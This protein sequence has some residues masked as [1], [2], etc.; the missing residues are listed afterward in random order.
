M[1]DFFN[2][3]WATRNIYD[4]TSDSHN[5]VLTN[6]ILEVPEFRNR[7]SYY[8]QKLVNSYAH[9]DNIFPI[10]D[11]LKEKI[12][13]FAE[14]DSYRTLD[15]GYSIEDFHDSYEEALGGHAKYGIKDYITA[16]RNSI[17]NQLQ[18][19]N[20]API[21]RRVH[22][23]PAIPPTNTPITFSAKRQPP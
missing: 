23:S 11:C 18:T 16:R 7:Y 6:R 14:A 12:T 20:I 1:I 10:I 9:P 19:P 15:Y 4:W 17:L 8:L 13:P 22:H 2:I 3:D 21:I 5:N